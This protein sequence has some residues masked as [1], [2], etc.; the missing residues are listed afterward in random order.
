MP[1]HIP[2]YPSA[3]GTKI[4]TDLNQIIVTRLSMGLPNRFYDRHFDGAK[5]QGILP[6]ERDG[7][8]AFLPS[9]QRQASR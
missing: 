2:H 1:D 9:I 5:V 8:F 6:I 4:R 7:R 3:E